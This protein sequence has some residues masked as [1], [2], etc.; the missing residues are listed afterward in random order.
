MYEVYVLKV[1]V[2]QCSRHSNYS[3][4]SK[5]Q[6]LIEKCKSD[7]DVHGLGWLR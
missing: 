5:I 1:K 3:N 2:Q 6:S 4:C 7:V